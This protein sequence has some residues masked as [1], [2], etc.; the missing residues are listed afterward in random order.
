MGRAILRFS[1]RL[2]SRFRSDRLSTVSV[3]LPYSRTTAFCSRTNIPNPCSAMFS[4][5]KVFASV[6]LAVL[7]ASSAT[8]VPF[9]ASSK[10]ATHR[11]REIS[12]E[13]KLEAYHPQSSYEVR[14][15]V[16]VAQRTPVDRLGFLDLRRGY[17]PPSLQARRRVSRRL[18][19]RLRPVAQQARLRRRPCPLDVR[20]RACQPCLRQAADKRHPLRQCGR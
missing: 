6:F 8:A 5:K 2:R 20:E 17:R 19:D 13:F 12:R 16:C 4:F 10:Y 9:P 11:T 18:C 15:K 3:T 14:P 1:R 7:C